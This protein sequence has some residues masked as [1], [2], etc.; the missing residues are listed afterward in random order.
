M[1]A[2]PFRLTPQSS[3]TA[4]GRPVESE[5][6]GELPCSRLRSL[7]PLRR[8][9]SRR[10]LQHFTA[11]ATRRDSSRLAVGQFDPE[12]SP[13]RIRAGGDIEIEVPQ[14]DQVRLSQAGL[15]QTSSSEDHCSTLVQERRRPGSATAAVHPRP[16]ASA[17][18]RAPVAVVL[19]LRWQRRTTRPRSFACS[20]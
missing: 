6:T 20:R 8:A 11:R 9:R 19:P 4:H 18:R 16:A 7:R 15:T 13:V 2:F 3:A 14:A 1:A 12:D 17:A 5:I 10:T